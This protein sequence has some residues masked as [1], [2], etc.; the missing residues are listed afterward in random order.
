M[1]LAAA[2]LAAFAAGCAAERVDPGPALPLSLAELELFEPPLADLRPAPG[3]YPYEV[4]AQLWA[5]GARKARFI[6]LPMGEQ[7]GFDPGESW[8]FPRG[9]LLIKNFYFPLDQRAPDG[10]RRIVETRLLR[11]EDDGFHGYV[12]LWNEAQTEAKLSPGGT[13]VDVAGVD[14]G[15]HAFGKEYV[16]PNTNQCSNCH[17]RA[18][19]LH[20]LGFITPQLNR[21]VSRGGEKVDQLGWLQQH[22]VFGGDPVDPAAQDHFADPYGS[23]PLE[24]RARAWLHANCA[25][26]HRSGGGA[27]STA[28]TLLASETDPT[29]LGVCKP[30]IAAGSGTG[31]HSFDVVPGKPDDSIMPFR[32]ASTAPQ[33]KMPELPNRTPDPAGLELVRQWI[34]AMP[35]MS[36]G[37]N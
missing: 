4:A 37:G 13:R 5:D 27:E 34:A 10:E 9:T 31:G 24:P 8:S 33:I 29:H 18:E 17:A 26:C 11:L 30:P 28:L 6:A 1:K 25:H 35:A 14:D 20:L 19:Q 15:G 12:Y 23:G 21:Q 32:V 3:V 22:G 2:V 7:A 16:V 36:C